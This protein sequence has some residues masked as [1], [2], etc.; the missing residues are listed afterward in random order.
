ME[1]EE[2]LIRE[3][4]GILPKSKKQ[5]NQ[6]YDADAEI[7]ELEG[8]NLC[9]TID[10]FSSEDMLREI[11]PETLGWNITVGCIS[12]I[13]ACGGIPKFFSHSFTIREDWTDKYINSFVKGVA[14]VLNRLEVGFLGGDF[15]V[16]DTW[17]YTGSVI[18]IIEKE[19]LLRSNAQEGDY[20]YITGKAGKGNIEAAYKM[21]SDK[22]ILNS[23][24]KNIKNKFVIREKEASLIRKYSKCC[25]DTSDGVFNTIKAI[26]YQSNCGFCVD[27]LKYEKSGEIISR[28]LNL[29]MELLFLGECGEYELMFT[30]PRENED[31]FLKEAKDKELKFYKI[32]RVLK[33]CRYYLENGK[34]K[35]ELTNFNIRARD[36][37]NK[38][39]YIKSI[40]KF[41]KL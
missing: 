35:L 13:F 27:N 20:I 39:D 12:D 7:F 17:R 37:K 1:R 31:L 25:M 6:V 34:T 32:G 14:D 28:I 30:I 5:K 11:D 15:G 23:L 36:Y 29:P 21:Y 26:A 9:N 40:V 18:G 22:L 38:K 8:I 16:S 3:M 19:M 24:I 4:N 33:E 41:L 2:R 10:E